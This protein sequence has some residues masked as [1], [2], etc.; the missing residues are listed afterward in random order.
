[1]PAVIDA[2]VAKIAVADADVEGYPGLWLR[3]N[4]DNSLSAV[5]PPF[6]LKE[7]LFRDRDLRVT[8]AADYIA[9]TTGTR[10]FPWRVLG[11]AQKDT[12]LL[13]NQ[14]VYLLAK[15]S[16]VQDTSWIR[17]GK[18]AWDWW[19]ANNVYGVDFKAGIN[20]ATYKYYIDFAAKYGLPYI[21]L[22]AGWYKGA[23][24]TAVIPDVNM[25]E[26]V[27]YGRQKSVGVIL[28]VFWKSMQDQMQSALDL[29]AK[30]G[31]KGIKVDF[32]QRNDQL[33]MRYYYTLSRECAKRHMLVDFHGAQRPASLTRTWPNLIG[34]E[35]VRGMEWSKWSADAEP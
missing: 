7:Q 11:I 3:G 28:W 4:G 19:N 27:A 21:I 9:V 33:L 26:L 14:I 23:D 5:F 6:P 20:T 17:P 25:E 1:V 10:T 32:M 8:R 31:I 30:G 18:V 2:R 35:G 34:S 15:P 22:D 24:I 16:Q 12:D 13:T 29:Y